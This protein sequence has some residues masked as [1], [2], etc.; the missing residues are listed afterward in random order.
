MAS[1]LSVR[2]PQ[3][4]AFEVSVAEEMR[5]RRGSTFCH[6]GI[7]AQIVIGIEI[8]RKANLLTKRSYLLLKQL[9]CNW[10]SSSTSGTHRV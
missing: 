5:V 1:V 7:G 2:A 9:W 10:R 3:Q 4:S 6:I 8:W